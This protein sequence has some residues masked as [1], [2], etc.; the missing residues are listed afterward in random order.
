[1]FDN[2]EIF[3][4]FFCNILLTFFDKQST[5]TYG[6]NFF[7]VL[8][9]IGKQQMIAEKKDRDE[10]AK[11]INLF[12]QKINEIGST[13]DENFIYTLKSIQ[14]SVFGNL[15][16]YISIQSRKIYYF[17]TSEYI[18]D[19]SN[20]DN[21]L[22]SLNNSIKFIENL[23]NKLSNT[24]NGNNKKGGELLST[25]ILISILYLIHTIITEELLK[26]TK[27]VIKEGE[28]IFHK[29]T[30]TSSSNSSLSKNKSSIGGFK[31]KNI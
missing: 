18:Y 6:G 20:N 1:M 16:Y 19:Y 3:I 24:N 31:F 12:G 9:N 14:K 28:S 26:F 25:T 27:K 23:I 15:E 8:L 11:N 4:K 17:I 10:M 7:N 21:T 29:F 5:I 22:T 2:I 30:D 13:F